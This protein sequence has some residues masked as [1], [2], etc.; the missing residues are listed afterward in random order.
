M[1]QI[2]KQYFKV[3]YLEKPHFQCFFFIIRNFATLD[4]SRIAPNIQMPIWWQH[5]H[6]VYDQKGLRTSI[7]KLFIRKQVFSSLQLQLYLGITCSQEKLLAFS[8]FN[9]IGVSE[10]TPA[11]LK[12]SDLDL[13][14]LLMFP[15]VSLVRIFFLLIQH[16]L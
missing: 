1:Y 12:T 3:S 9:F 4:C 5:L 8:V 10:K 6:H 11:T 16:M 7:L 14:S 13:A 2:F 15:L